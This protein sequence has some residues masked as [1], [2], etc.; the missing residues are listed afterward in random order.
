M[1]GDR[2]QAQ[3]ERKDKEFMISQ[4]RLEYDELLIKYQKV[5]RMYSEYFFIFYLF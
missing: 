3:R 1:E 4:M 5:N 2:N